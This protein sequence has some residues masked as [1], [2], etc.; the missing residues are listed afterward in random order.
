MNLVTRKDKLVA[1]QDF[2]N[3]ETND[4]IPND[5][6]PG[7]GSILHDKLLIQKALNRRITK[8]SKCT[9][10]NVKGF[11]ES[12]HGF[13]NLNAK[14]FFIGEAPCVKSMTLD[15][16]FAWKS[17][18][19]LDI[20]LNL[21]SLTRYDVF[22]SNAI[23]CRLAQKRTPTNKEI[24]RCRF[25]LCDELELVQPKVVIA[26]GA[27]AKTSMYYVSKSKTANPDILAY[28][29]LYVKHP[30]AFLYN[31]F[32]LQDYILKTSLTIDKYK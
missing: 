30:A 27:S 21:S 4:L 25:H 15:F 28:K 9:G 26:L 13:G 23:H 24:R 6:L 8:C 11:T 7:L 3:L 10:L 22:I 20:I 14:I 16:P 18:K 32:G 31:D 29:I 19:L 2:I 5:T 12:A 1:L 17:G